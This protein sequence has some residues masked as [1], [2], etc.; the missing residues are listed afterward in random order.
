MISNNNELVQHPEEDHAIQ[1]LRLKAE[2]EQAKAAKAWEEKRAAM[3]Q[4]TKEARRG[5]VE[6][7]ARQRA[8]RHLDEVN[9][10]NTEDPAGILDQA[11]EEY[12]SGEFFL[13]EFFKTFLF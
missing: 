3:A 5:L 6:K 12:L 9:M 13:R 11:V 1:E 10:R 4:Q 8:F 7:V 2:A